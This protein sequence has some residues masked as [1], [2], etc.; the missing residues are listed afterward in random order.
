VHLPQADCQQIGCQGHGV[1]L[2]GGESP[3]G[4]FHQSPQQGSGVHLDGDPGQALSGR[5][6][7]DQGAPIAARGLFERFG[8]RHGHRGDR[9]QLLAQRGLEGL[10]GLFP[11]V[12]QGQVF[13]EAQVRHQGAALRLYAVSGF[14]GRGQAVGGHH[15]SSL[16][17]RSHRL[18]ATDHLQDHR[19][20]LAAQQ[21]AVILLEEEM[22][23]L[24]SVDHRLAAAA[25][26]RGAVGGF[27]VLVGIALRPAG[28]LA[29]QGGDVRIVDGHLVGR[30]PADGHHVRGGL[31]IEGL[32]RGFKFQAQQG[33][34][35]PEVRIPLRSVRPH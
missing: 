31:E 30:R 32:A 20:L 10:T 13:H 14:A 12:G 19:F 17:G 29:V 35:S 26:H 7:F 18:D 33:T 25:L 2:G 28:D 8:V 24:D 22:N 1:D 9:G 11:V 21:D 34:G 5:I 23:H 15:R 3:A 6:G 4:G 16:Q 27:Q